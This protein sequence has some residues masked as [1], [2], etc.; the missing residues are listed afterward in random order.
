[1]GLSS[2]SVA[3]FAWGDPALEPTGS[4]V[5]LTADSRWAQTKEYFP[6]LLLPVSLS[7]W[8]ATATPCLCRRPF[9]TSR[10]VWFSLLWGHCSFPLGSDVHTTLCVPSKSGVSVSPSPVK[11][12]QWNP[13]SLQSLILW[14]FLLMLLDPQVGKPD[15]GLRTL[16]LVGGLLWYIVLQFVSHPPSGYGIWFYCDCTT[17]AISLW[18][19]LCLWMWGIFFGEF[20]CLPFDHCSAVSCDFSALTRRSERTSFYSTILNQSPLPYLL[21]LLSPILISN[22]RMAFLQSI[23][24]LWYTANISS[25]MSTI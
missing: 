17:P 24:W 7:P 18:L 5:W 15:V 14:E 6:E 21:C 4:L 8:W 16:T 13:A 22:K 3:C 1:M 2:L 20:Q 12:L 11:V 10:C 19:L 25:M 23:L 9:N